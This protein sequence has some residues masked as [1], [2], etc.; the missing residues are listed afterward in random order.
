MANNRPLQETY[1]TEIAPPPKGRSVME[2]EDFSS[3]NRLLAQVRA[4]SAAAAQLA[5]KPAAEK[6]AEGNKE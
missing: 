2:G 3:I 5:P 1:I 4:A 6:T